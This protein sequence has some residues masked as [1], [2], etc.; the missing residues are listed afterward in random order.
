MEW[1]DFLRRV[2]NLGLRRAHQR[3]GVRV[4]A[5]LAPGDIGVVVEIDGR[6]DAAL[7]RDEFGSVCWAV[8]S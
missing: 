1:A 3:E 5:M 4:D 8:E 6:R 2:F 7:V